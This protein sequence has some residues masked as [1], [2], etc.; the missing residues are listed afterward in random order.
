MGVAVLS[1]ELQAVNASTNDNI[2]DDGFIAESR[3][4]RF[5]CMITFPY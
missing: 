3:L 2:S 4:D 1:V 5:F